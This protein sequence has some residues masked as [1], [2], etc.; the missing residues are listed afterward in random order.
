MLVRNVQ[1]LTPGGLATA[2]DVEIAAHGGPDSV[3]G[4]GC[5]L[6]PGW[7]DLHA[8]L[9]DPGFPEKETLESGARSAAA[10]GFTHVVAM[11]NTRPVTDN[12]ALLRTQAGRAAGLGIRVSF[13]GALTHGL[14][15]GRLTDPV[16]LK[17]AGAVAL[18]DDGRH[19]M[20]P[21]TLES[22]LSRA[23]DAGLPVL[24]HAQYET[25]ERSAFDEARATYDAI[26]ALRRVPGAR[27]HLQHVSTRLAVQL[28]REAKAGSLPVTAEATPH[29]L[30][31]TADKVE[32]MGREAGVN[33]P[34]RTAS[35]R[36][37]LVEGLR[38]GTIDAIATDHAPHEREAKLNG[39]Y[40]FHGFETAL[41]VVLSLGLP[42][43]VVYRACVKRP[44]EIVGVSHS[45]DWVLFDPSA[46]WAV[47]PEAFHSLGHNSPFAGRELPGVVVA[48]V[49]RGEFIYGKVPVG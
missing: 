47:D 25:A 20:S 46:T 11:A 44:S 23:S 26:E 41:G 3:D 39:A 42:W 6:S 32:W 2:R 45:D 31:L 16:A 48:T 1:M 10:G 18:S 5:V 43:D 34:L 33:P 13:V 35:D 27:L 9:R 40:G 49:A 22:G 30:A 28:I 8:H 15:G 29:H 14:E 21:P 17:E 19:A 37:A 4:T 36:A 24:V 12:P 38:E 7:I